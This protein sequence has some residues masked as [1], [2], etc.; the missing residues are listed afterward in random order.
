MEIWKRNLLI[1]WIGSLITASSFSMVIPFLP[2]FLSQIGVHQHVALWSG[3]LY[4]AAF[5]AG[6]ISSPYW[7]SQRQIWS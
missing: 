1:L 7:G 6:A 5:F 3:C 2:L 4:S